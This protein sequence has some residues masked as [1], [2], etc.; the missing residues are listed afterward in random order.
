M[1]VAEG[2]TSES[3][4]NKEL[5]PP[6]SPKALKKWGTSM[7]EM[8]AEA[9]GL[10]SSKAMVKAK[11][12]G[13]A[14]A[15]PPPDIDMPMAP[16]VKARL[17]PKSLFK[18]PVDIKDSSAESDGN[19]AANVAPISEVEGSTTESDDN[20]VTVMGPLKSRPKPKLKPLVEVGGLSTESDLEVTSVHVKPR[21][22][23]S[24]AAVGSKEVKANGGEKNKKGKREDSI[25]SK[26]DVKKK[27][28][29]AKAVKVV[30]ELQPPKLTI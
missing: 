20:T 21:S 19:V 26:T 3:D 27:G 5:A 11:A 4:S 15:L 28:V 22:N 23:S 12:K 8:G 9:D 18:A 2:T 29:K 17:S 14:K 30:K 10:A 13:K 24:S 1:E 25:G 16:L 6:L 7:K